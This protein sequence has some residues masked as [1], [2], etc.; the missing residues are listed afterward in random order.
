MFTELAK[1]DDEEVVY[2]L[3][4]EYPQVAAYVLSRLGTDKATN[5][6]SAMEPGLAADL[7]LRT[8]SMGSPKKW[9]TDLAKEVLDR[10]SSGTYDFFDG[11]KFAAVVVNSM[12]LDTL[13]KF[14]LAADEINEET[15]N[16]IRED[17]TDSKLAD[18][19]LTGEKY[20]LS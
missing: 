2:V 1:C 20:E 11:K 10:A 3:S 4:K 6:L 9:A 14:F 18:L 12:E 5:V 19:N 15:S 8:R 17:V 7:V 13:K 16:E